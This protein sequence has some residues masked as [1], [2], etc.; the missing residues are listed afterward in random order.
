[1]FMAKEKQTPPLTARK[2]S[3]EAEAWHTFQREQRQKAPERMEDA[4]KFLAG[5]IS[6]S[7]TIFLKLDENLFKYNLGE[8]PVIVALLLWLV[9]LVAAFIVL[10]PVPF[11]YHKSSAEDIERMHGEVTRYKYRWLLISVVAYGLALGVVA[12]IFLMG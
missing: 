2:A 4:A 1:M 6:I 12:G 10:F 9:A 8:W 5:M 3:S 7:L 11:R